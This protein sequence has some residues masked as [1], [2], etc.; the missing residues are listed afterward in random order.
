MEREK[1]IFF[2]NLLLRAFVIGLAFALFYFG[3]TYLFW[4]TAVSWA[5]TFKVDEKQL[6]QLLLQFFTNIRLV[7]VFF[8]LVPALALHWSAKR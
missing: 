3:A 2:R 8:F 4:N 1:I 6:G 5:A 7:L